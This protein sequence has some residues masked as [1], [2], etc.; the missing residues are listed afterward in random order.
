MEQSKLSTILPFEEPFKML[1]QPNTNKSTREV[2]CKNLPEEQLS[3]R[4]TLFDRM[5]FL[6][7]GRLLKLSELPEVFNRGV[8][9]DPLNSFDLGSLESRLFKSFELEFLE[10][11]LSS[12]EERLISLEERRN[13]SEPF[14]PILLEFLLNPS[15]VDDL[16]ALSLDIALVDSF[17]L[18]WRLMLSRPD[19]SSDLC[20]LALTDS[21]KLFQL[22]FFLDFKFTSEE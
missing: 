18:V 5:S 7:D 15:L 10:D 22:S 8:R 17:L 13:T 11:C 2:H 6:Y 19:L 4:L 12:L 9:F 3:H 16:R 1:Q 20:S 14:S 21:R